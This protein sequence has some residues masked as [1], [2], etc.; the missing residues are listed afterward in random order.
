MKRSVR[1]WVLRGAPRGVRKLPGPLRV[2]GRTAQR[3]ETHGFALRRVPSS[4]GGAVDHVADPVVSTHALRAPLTLQRVVT[5]FVGNAMARRASVLRG[6]N[7]SPEA[8]A[9][10]EASAAE[11]EEV[12][13][14]RVRRSEHPSV[15]ARQSPRR[16]P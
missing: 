13:H 11:A 12:S 8:A 5:I 10:Q 14:G 2:G 15:R 7:G 9:V 16:F 3:K 4:A 6:I 1:A